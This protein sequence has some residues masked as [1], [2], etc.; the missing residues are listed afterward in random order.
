MGIMKQ[1]LSGVA[2][3]HSKKYVHRELSPQNIL[4]DRDLHLKISDH[5]LERLIYIREIENEA[6]TTSPYTDNSYLW[7]MAPEII[8]S[9][10]DYRWSGSA[11]P[12]LMNSMI[13]V[14]QNRTGRHNCRRSSKRSSVHPRTNG[15]N[16]T[17]FTTTISRTLPTVPCLQ[18][19]PRAASCPRHSGL[20]MHCWCSGL[21][22]G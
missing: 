22:K 5:G 19:S 9:P 10:N 20:S 11:R 12:V 21:S 14:S 4:L 7:Y 16:I 1:L 15:K 13:L 18:T 17:P 3:L 2:Y 6:R 8:L